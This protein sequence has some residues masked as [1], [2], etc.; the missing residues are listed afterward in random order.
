MDIIAKV[1]VNGGITQDSHYHGKKQIGKDLSLSFVYHNNDPDHENSHFWEATPCG[2]INMRIDNQTATDQ[3]VPGEELYMI[4][5][6]EKPK[7]L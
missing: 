5:T 6:K 1:R 3:L 2:N 4:L 7:G